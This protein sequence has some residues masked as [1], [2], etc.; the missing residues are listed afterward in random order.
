MCFNTP[1]KFI[2]KLLILGKQHNDF[3]NHDQLIYDF[4]LKFNNDNNC[5]FNVNVLELHKH[6]LYNPH[7]NQLQYI[8]HRHI[9][10]YEHNVG[11]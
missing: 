1:V 5:D 3:H 4:H 10:N 2:D 11:N 8:V 6:N 9:N 7:I